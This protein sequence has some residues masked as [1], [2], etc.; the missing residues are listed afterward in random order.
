MD[1]GTRVKICKPDGN[2]MNLFQRVSL[3]P[4]EINSVTHDFNP[5]G[6]W[7]GGQELEYIPVLAE[8]RYHGGSWPH[9]RVSAHS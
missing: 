1:D 5:V 3:S 9:I 6:I 7:V 8:W 2:V 4:V